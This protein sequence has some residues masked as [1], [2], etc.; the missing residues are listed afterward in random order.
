[1]SETVQDTWYYIE[2]SIRRG[3]LDPREL[4]A[5]IDARVIAA[6][7]LVWRRGMSGW[8]AAV[9]TE[10][11]SAIAEVPPAIPQQCCAPPP[12]PVEAT[13]QAQ[14]A[15]AVKA[16]PAAPPL[17]VAVDSSPA[18]APNP[19]PAA[20]LGRRAWKVQAWLAFALAV[21]FCVPSAKLMD[22][23]P[24]TYVSVATVAWWMVAMVHLRGIAVAATPGARSLAPLFGAILLCWTL[25]VASGAVQGWVANGDAITVAETAKFYGCI[26]AV[27]AMAV[28]WAPIHVAGAAGHTRYRS[29]L[30]DHWKGALSLPLAYW[31]NLFLANIALHLVA[32]VWADNSFSFQPFAAAAFLFGLWL[33][34]VQ[35]IVWQCVGVWRSAQAHTSRGGAGW[36]AVLAQ[37]ALCIGML[38]NATTLVRDALPQVAFAA[39]MFLGDSSIEDPV[40]TVRDGTLVYSGG[41]KNRSY[42]AVQQA[43]AA[44]PQVRVLQLET[45]GGRI[46]SAERLAA[47][48]REN[49]LTT[50][51]PSHCA[52]AGMIVFL[53]G[54]RRVT[55]IGAKLG[56]HSGSSPI[57]TDKGEQING[58]LTSALQ[59]R[60]VSEAFIRRARETPSDDMWYPTRSELAEEGIVTEF[61]LGEKLSTDSTDEPIRETVRR[62][63][64]KNPALVALA[65]MEPQRFE[66]GITE[67]IERMVEGL[68]PVAATLASINPLL[69]EKLVERLPYATGEVLDQFFDL[70]LVILD[71]FGENRPT[72][73]LAYWSGNGDFS[74]LVS[75]PD[76][77]KD[78]EQKLVS[79]LLT[80]PPDS[81]PLDQER[82]KVALLQV[83]SE[84]ADDSAELSYMD[85]VTRDPAKS[86]EIIRG[87][88]RASQQLPPEDRHALYRFLL[89]GQ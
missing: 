54:E 3:P 84:I 4:A 50:Y 43:I 34:A 51:V 22:G 88:I 64:L 16:E 10:L 83:V 71:T 40:I 69:R 13:A 24:L 27:G 67:L 73:A 55:N 23:S 1:M 32:L 11:R 46:A 59:R 60:G 2:G 53:A 61:R 70:N 6:D 33:A 81:S 15:L 8:R 19:N 57:A 86:L 68:N 38:G 85:E 47:L 37:V 39:E 62:N 36:A 28:L 75:E 12:L 74:T 14:A 18:M 35:L 66:E 29:Y 17:P 58:W 7:T 79:D 44:N 78:K 25:F 21:G 72:A 31:V 56:F 87:F 89:K 52:S 45:Q 42:V 65:E 49:D 9:A 77:P 30:L 20:P 48:V 80:Q 63:L 5:L 26:A 82:A 41:I 76:Y